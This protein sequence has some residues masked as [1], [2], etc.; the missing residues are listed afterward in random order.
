MRSVDIANI[1]WALFHQDGMYYIKTTD[2]K[3]ESATFSVTG[4]TLCTLI[5]YIHRHL[6]HPALFLFRYTKYPSECMGSE[7]LSKRLLLTMGKVGKD[8]ETF[9]THSLREATATHLL[10]QGTPISQVQV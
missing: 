8:T 6:Q 9:K 10:A 3:G 4:I 7:L 1:A 2:K 5:E